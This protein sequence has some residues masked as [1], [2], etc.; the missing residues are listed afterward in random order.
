MID[1][2]YRQELRSDTSQIIFPFM[3]IIV[4]F[5][6]MVSAL[7]VGFVE[8]W[9]FILYGVVGPLSAII[10]WKL[11]K[12]GYQG[13]GAWFYTIANLFMISLILVVLYKP[14]DIGAY[15]YTYGIFIVIASMILP[16]NSGII[17]W[18]I[19]FAFM[20][21]GFGIIGELSFFTVLAYLPAIFINFM[22]SVVAYECHGMA[23]CG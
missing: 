18:F 13:W 9:A 8:G 3:S 19:A 23:G 21:M 5:A 15:P 4:V 1:Q 7:S 10:A 12:K 6:M 17:S 2:E 14:G 20:L 11:I 16:P 22:L